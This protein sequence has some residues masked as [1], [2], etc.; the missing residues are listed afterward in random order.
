MQQPRRSTSMR[1]LVT[2]AA[3]LTLAG[4]VSQREG[5]E[6]VDKVVKVPSPPDPRDSWLCVLV[7]RGLTR[8]GA[9]RRG[10]QRRPAWTTIWT[11]RVGRFPSG[12]IRP[13]CMIST[14]VS[15]PP[16]V[17]I[18]PSAEALPYP[19][20]AAIDCLNRPP[21]SSRCSCA[22]TPGCGRVQGR[23]CRRTRPA[24]QSS[25]SRRDTWCSR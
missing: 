16:R 2:I 13:P 14:K 9:C 17:A 19:P 3:F 18:Q 25:S 4:A 20:P 1:Y 12:T 11:S 5:P 21:L 23:G 6:T 8:S 15:L 24:C 22:L 10:Y 7:G